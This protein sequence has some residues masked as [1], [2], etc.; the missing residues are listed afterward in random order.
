MIGFEV[1]TVHAFPIVN[2][3]ISDMSRHAFF[4]CLSLPLELHVLC[5]KASSQ[6]LARPGVFGQVRQYAS[7]S[8]VRSCTR[9][10]PS[11]LSAALASSYQV[12][13][14]IT[15]RL[16]SSSSN[17][18]VTFF[19]PNL[20]RQDNRNSPAGCSEKEQN[21]I[22]KNWLKAHLRSSS[23]QD[24][25]VLD[26]EDAE[27]T[28]IFA[29]EDRK[30]RAARANAQLTLDDE[31]PAYNTEGHGPSYRDLVIRCTTFDAEGNIQKHSEPVAKN[32]LCAQH[33]LQPRDLR[34]IDSRIPNVIPTMCVN[35]SSFE[36]LV[37][38]TS[39]RS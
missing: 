20:Q 16:A 37:S 10:R 18:P 38:R 3:S 8:Q 6:N 27:P 23:Q 30:A 7:I 19:D 13:H 12:H 5:H 26:K 36:V 15:R 21:D 28:A 31:P 25:E 9:A 32:A 22:E 39:C 1:C 35:L 24:V 29:A 33:N 14:R 4:S 2:T 34:K 17:A 11:L